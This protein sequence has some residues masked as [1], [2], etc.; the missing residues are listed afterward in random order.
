MPDWTTPTFLQQ[1]PLDLEAVSSSPH[2]SE[3]LVVLQ[4]SEVS[5]D[6][7]DPA[8]NVRHKESRLIPHYLFPPMGNVISNVFTSCKYTSHASLIHEYSST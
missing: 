6:G 1:A 8:L 3:G 7:R 4:D 2:P 5:Q